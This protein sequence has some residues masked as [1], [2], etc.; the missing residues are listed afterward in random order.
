MTMKESESKNENIAAVVDNK[1]LDQLHHK[2]KNESA[3]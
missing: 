3:F 1:S 2:K